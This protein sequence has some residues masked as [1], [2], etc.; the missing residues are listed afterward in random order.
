MSN[1]AF[2]IIVCIFRVRD[3]SMN[4]R[5]TDSPRLVGLKLREGTHDILCPSS[6]HVWSHDHNVN[7]LHV[8]TWDC[9]KVPAASA[10]PS[11]I[12][13]SQ[14]DCTLKKPPVTLK[15]ELES[16]QNGMTFYIKNKLHPVPSDALYSYSM[17]IKFWKRLAAADETFCLWRGNNPDAM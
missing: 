7:L 4:G 2:I 8:C 1:F 12:E 14:F 15:N 13:I 16:E 6:G 11:Q 5:K 17:H 9:W 3:V 10:G